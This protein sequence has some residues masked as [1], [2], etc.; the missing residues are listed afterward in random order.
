MFEILQSLILIGNILFVDFARVS[1]KMVDDLSCFLLLFDN[2]PESTSFPLNCWLLILGVRLSGLLVY[3]LV[4]I[5]VVLRHF[6]FYNKWN[7]A[8]NFG[9]NADKAR[10]PTWFIH[11]IYLNRS[12]D[13][14]INNWHSNVEPQKNNKHCKGIKTLNCLV[15]FTRLFDPD[16]FINFDVTYN[17]IM[18]AHN[19]ITKIF[20]TLP[21]R[22]V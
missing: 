14:I 11:Y 9:K 17:A 22:P 2:V 8:I 12:R 1:L 5:F 18:S 15:E 21:N 19:N 6:H 7:P 13:C 10:L 4:P 16:G 3:L 20:K